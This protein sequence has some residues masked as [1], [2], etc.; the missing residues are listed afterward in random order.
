MFLFF[1][2]DTAPTE[3]YTPSRP[4]ALPIFCLRFAEQIDGQLEVAIGLET[5]HPQVLRRLN[6][7]MTLDDFE[8]AVQFLRGNDI[9]VRAFI[10]LR[11]P[12]LSEQEGIDWA[13]RSLEFAFALGVGCCAVIP[14][15]AGNG[16]MQQLESQTLFTPPSLRSLEF[17]TQAGLQM[18]AGRV[19]ADLWD[20]ETLTACVDCG[21]QRIQRIREMN[22][23]QQVPPALKC[24]CEERR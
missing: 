5:V 14:T 11:P 18:N 7:Q 17:V 21:P 9:D 4:D 8:R 10:L 6:K 12:Y 15:R 2:N 16:V 19:F 20:I 23:T 1:F 24:Q 3:I 22:L 13:L